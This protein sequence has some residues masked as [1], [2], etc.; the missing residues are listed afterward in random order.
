MTKTVSM[1][2]AKA[3]LSELA[4]RAA[5][6]E[7]FTL[8]RRGKPVASLVGP[9]DLEILEAASRASTFVEAL[10]AFRRRHR[11]TLP[12]DPL[13]VPRSAGRRPA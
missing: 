11:R 4:S 8:L 2:A 1:A 13:I 3:S 12:R 6:G 7:R 10:E 5:A 9:A